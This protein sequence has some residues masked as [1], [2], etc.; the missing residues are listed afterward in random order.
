MRILI[1]YYIVSSL[2]VPICLREA[3]P[4]AP[5]LSG[6]RLRKTRAAGGR[7]VVPTQRFAR[8]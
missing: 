5:Q 6:R 8:Y 4:F 1:R 2:L 7:M 3:L